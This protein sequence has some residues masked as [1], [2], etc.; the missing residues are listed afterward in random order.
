MAETIAFP[1]LASPSQANPAGPSTHCSYRQH[2]ARQVCHVASVRI[3]STQTTRLEF[4]IREYGRTAGPQ[5]MDEM[6][7]RKMEP[8]PYPANPKGRPT[9]G[10]G[11]RHEGLPV[12]PL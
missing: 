11:K 6:S 1:Y 8:C 9:P 7:D 10:P 5:R 3:C 2:S 4:L 12:Y